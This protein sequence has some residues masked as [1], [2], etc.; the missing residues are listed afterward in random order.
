MGFLRRWLRQGSYH[1]EQL[2]HRADRQPA[3]RG[4]L[5]ELV[6]E[7]RRSHRD[8]TLDAPA[9]PHHAYGTEASL[10]GYAHQGQLQTVER[11]RWVS[12]AHGLY[13]ERGYL[14]GGIVLRGL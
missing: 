8:Q 4:R 14:N 5:Q 10:P 3:G 9:D 1:R 7:V 12:D 11:M 13:R 6:R 2:L